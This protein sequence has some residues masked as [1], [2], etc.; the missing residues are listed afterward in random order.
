[1]DDPERVRVGEGL[2][3]LEHEVDGLLDRQRPALPGA[4]SAR[5][6]PSRYSMTM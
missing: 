4:M 2:A 3:G 5:S 6:L 1:M